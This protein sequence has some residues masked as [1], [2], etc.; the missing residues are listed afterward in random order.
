M[1]LNVPIKLKRKELRQRISACLSIQSTKSCSISKTSCTLRSKVHRQRSPLI[2]KEYSLPFSTPLA[3]NQAL[4]E[5]AKFT[6]KSGVD[7]VRDSFSESGIKKSKSHHTPNWGVSCTNTMSLLFNK[8]GLVPE[9]SLPAKLK[10]DS[11]YSS[12]PKADCSDS[13]I[14]FLETQ[15]ARHLNH[16]I[17]TNQLMNLVENLKEGIF[18]LK[19]RLSKSEFLRKGMELKLACLHG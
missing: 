15:V 13:S 5:V 9:S 6:K 16:S 10:S 14:E 17:N 1:N 4:E 18:L 12:G 19:L 2:I 11:D 8:K 3:D 7:I